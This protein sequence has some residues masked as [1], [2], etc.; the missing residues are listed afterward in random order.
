[1]NFVVKKGVFGQ[2]NSVFV[3]LLGFNVATVSVSL[4][5]Y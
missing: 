4:K 3:F 5:L 2:S 1:M